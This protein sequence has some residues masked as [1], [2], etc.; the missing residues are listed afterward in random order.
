MC[1]KITDMVVGGGGAVCASFDFFLVR[2]ISTFVMMIVF[3]SSVTVLP[4]LN[5]AHMLH[6]FRGWK[7]V[8][9]TLPSGRNTLSDQKDW[10][11]TSNY[12]TTKIFWHLNQIAND[13]FEIFI[14]KMFRM[15]SGP[16][17]LYF[18]TIGCIINMLRA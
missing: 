8:S 7:G 12:E 10:F 15:N 11:L 6:C 9:A 13:A 18:L 5:A 14:T 4:G 16:S 17:V 3:C 2:V 1:L